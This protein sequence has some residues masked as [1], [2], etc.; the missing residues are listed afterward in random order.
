MSCRVQIGNHSVPFAYRLYLR[1][2]TVRNLNRG[3]AKEERLRFQP[4]INWSGRCFSSSSLYTQRMA[5][6]RLFDSWY[7]S[8]K[9]LKFVRRQGKRWFCWALSNPIA[10]LMA[11]V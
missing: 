2:K 5:G 6:V 7:A 1:A 3:R 4:S 10:F 8:A 11:S 9:L